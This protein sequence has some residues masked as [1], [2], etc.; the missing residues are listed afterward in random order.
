MNGEIKS[1]S[2][3]RA[4]K[5]SNSRAD[6]TCSTTT[7]DLSLDVLRD[8]AAKLANTTS[9]KKDDSILRGGY[10]NFMQPPFFQLPKH[11]A[12]YDAINIL[13]QRFTSLSPLVVQLNA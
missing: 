8:L 9:S 3:P 2:S 7:T 12:R 13:L 10:G 11:D 4:R 5:G 6:S 1:M